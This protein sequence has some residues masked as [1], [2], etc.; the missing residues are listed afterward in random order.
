MRML[1]L[2][3]ILTQVSF[4]A[5]LSE[6]IGSEK[7]ETSIKKQKEYFISFLQDTP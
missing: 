7:I 1:L 5:T 3:L 4:A 6:F 2:G